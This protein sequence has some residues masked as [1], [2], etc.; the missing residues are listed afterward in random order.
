MATLPGSR[1][2]V[3]VGPP[4]SASVPRLSWALVTVVNPGHV[5]S[6]SKFIPSALKVP[7]MLKQ[8]PPEVLLAT[9]E[10]LIVIVFG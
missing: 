1:A 8:S 5:P 10:F 2:W 3:W 9:I 6:V 7:A 4:L